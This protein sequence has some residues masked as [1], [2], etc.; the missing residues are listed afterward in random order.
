MHQH[1]VNVKVNLHLPIV[2]M[3]TMEHLIVPVARMASADIGVLVLDLINVMMVV[4]VETNVVKRVP[5][6][7]A[8]VFHVNPVASV[9]VVPKIALVVMYVMRLMIVVKQRF[10]NDGTANVH[11]RAPP[12]A[13]E[14]PARGK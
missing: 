5:P 13:H 14:V 3:A 9:L 12:V 1:F 2:P 8:T 4:Q 7:L 10:V 11:I 6:I